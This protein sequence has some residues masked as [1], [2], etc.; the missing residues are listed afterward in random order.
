[1]IEFLAR[2]RQALTA[3]SALIDI[4]QSTTDYQEVGIR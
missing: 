3:G 4:A 1:V 2:R